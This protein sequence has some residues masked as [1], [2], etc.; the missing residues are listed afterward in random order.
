MTHKFT[1]TTDI[2][3]EKLITRAF[4]SMSE[5]EQSRL[6]LI[7]SRVLRETGKNKQKKLNKMPWW[8]VLLLAGGFA[9]AAWWAGELIF[10]K[11][12]IEISD[13]PAVSSDKIGNKQFELNRD[14]PQTEQNEQENKVY[15]EKDS[16]IIYQRESF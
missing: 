1:P 16:P 9:T 7:E 12:N 13:K 6:S 11:Q 4:E 10:D 5:A 15:E 8:I 14:E 2:G 3:L